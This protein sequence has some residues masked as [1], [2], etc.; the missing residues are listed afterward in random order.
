[1][2]EIHSNLRARLVLGPVSLSADNSPANFNLKGFNA[3]MLLIAVGIG[4]ITFTST[5]KIEF[6]LRH[7]DTTTVG[8]HAAV[9][10]DDVVILLPDGTMGTVSS[11]GIVRSLTAAH[12]SPTVTK[13][14]YVG[15]KQN[16]SLLADF[17]GTHTA[18]SP[19][20]PSPTPIMAMLVEG[21]PHHAPVG[22]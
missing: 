2:Q 10:D 4:G 17:G 11:G 19:A 16:I 20:A 5:N 15:N 9:E 1:M 12:A 14:G 8:E 13:I 22:V 7:G 18:G 21:K 6:K 3:A